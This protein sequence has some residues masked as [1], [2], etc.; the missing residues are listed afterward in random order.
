MSLRVSTLYTVLKD[1]V[2]SIIFSLQVPAAAVH[3]APKYRV[4]SNVLV[5]SQVARLPGCQVA[6][7]Q[8][9]GDGGLQREA[10]TFPT[11]ALHFPNVPMPIT[12]RNMMLRCHGPNLSIRRSAVTAGITA[13]PTNHLGSASEASINSNGNACGCILH[14]AQP[15]TPSRALSS[16]PK[17]PQMKEM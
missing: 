12:G 1:G 16:S 4:Q 11:A 7:G 13:P 15:S 2:R 3:V 6:S 8:R 9:P 17:C 5:G 10:C 14:V